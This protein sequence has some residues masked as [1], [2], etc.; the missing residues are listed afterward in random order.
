MLASTF[1]MICFSF[2]LIITMS[3]EAFVTPH[4][5]MFRRPLY[6]MDT[7]GAVTASPFI[8]QLLNRNT[9]KFLPFNK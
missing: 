4:F 1:V 9:V 8:R 7:D 2:A 3:T 6:N 5:V